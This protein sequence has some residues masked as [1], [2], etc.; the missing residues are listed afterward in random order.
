MTSDDLSHLP[1]DRTRD[2]R[3]AFLV[4][5]ICGAAGTLVVLVAGW[6]LIH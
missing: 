5:V 6:F 2:T 4:G 1:W 3:H